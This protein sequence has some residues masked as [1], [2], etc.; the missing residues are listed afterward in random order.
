M[1]VWKSTA[2][3]SDRL[4]EVVIRCGVH[5]RVETKVHQGGCLEQQLHGKGEDGDLKESCTGVLQV[6]ASDK[7]W[8]LCCLEHSI[9]FKVSVHSVVQLDSFSHLVRGACLP[10]MVA[11][12]PRLPVFP[13]T[14]PVRLCNDGDNCSLVPWNA[15]ANCSSA[16]CMGPSH[17]WSGADCWKVLFT[18]GKSQNAASLSSSPPKAR[19]V[20]E[21]TQDAATAASSDLELLWSLEAFS[22]H[23]PELFMQRHVLAVT[24]HKDVPQAI[25]QSHIPESIS[26]CSS[27]QC[28]RNSAAVSREHPP[29]LVSFLRLVWFGD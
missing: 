17:G 18:Q 22:R 10:L 26:S 3:E 8:G 23:V 28:F 9:S 20:S 24:S 16:L 14:R 11:H 19:R 13:R 25:S 7:S 6:Q 29:H 2:Q 27:L 15:A 4:T 5:A 21:V 12:R 1:L